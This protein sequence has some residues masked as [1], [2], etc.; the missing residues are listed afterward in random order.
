M[1][2]Q[3]VFDPGDLELLL[4]EIISTMHQGGTFHEM[5][6]CDEDSGLPEIPNK[7]RLALLM[8]T[9]TRPG[10]IPSQLQ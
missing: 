9:A 5:S 6:L 7:L 10:R 3:D 4:Q 8:A 2:S 1:P